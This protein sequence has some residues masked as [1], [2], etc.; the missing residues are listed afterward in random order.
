ML[1]A[2]V[3]GTYAR[4]ALVSGDDI[5]HVRVVE[6]GRFGSLAEACRAYL[7][8]VPDTP[9]PRV[10]G[11][12]VAAPVLGDRVDLTNRDWS[13]SITGLRQ[14]LGLERLEVL[15]D[16][17]ALALALPSLAPES[18]RGI[19]NGVAVDGAPIGLVGPGTGFGAAVLVRHGGRLLPLASEAGHADLAA[20]TRREWRIRQQFARRFGHVSVERAL[21]GPGLVNIVTAIRA[22]DGVDDATELTP[23]MVIDGAKEGAADC[24]EAI[25]LFSGWLGAFAGDLALAFNARGGMFLGGGLLPRMEGLFDAELFRR[26]FVDK[27]RL[28]GALESIPV[29]LLTG[30]V[31]ALTGVAAWM[32]QGR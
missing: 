32:V 9:A 22:L 27:G 13:F 26:R 21:S 3:G 11:F 18:R 23:R 5:E 15:N 30:S 24:R 14:E 19:K 8:D 2:D 12:A 4:F 10:A 25:A 28:R 31:P 17:E 1:V 20:T 6:C 29:D 16:F 7:A